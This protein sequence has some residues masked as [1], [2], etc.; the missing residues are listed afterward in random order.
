MVIV[1]LVFT[2]GTISEATF[3]EKKTNR[4]IEK[5]D[6]RPYNGRLIVYV[7]EQVSRWNMQDG[8]PY[9]FGFLDFAFD[10]KLSIEYLDTG[11][12]FKN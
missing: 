10:D 3:I 12:Y 5:L 4:S 9:H 11:T 6:E 8:N 7:V 2:I 1:L